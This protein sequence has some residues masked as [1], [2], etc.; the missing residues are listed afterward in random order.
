MSNQVTPM[1]ESVPERTYIREGRNITCYE[2][3][4]HQDPESSSYKVTYN[5]VPSFYF[6]LPSA[7][8]AKLVMNDMYYGEYTGG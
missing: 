2:V 6:K 5:A 7:A 1:L 3:L 8:A 4:E